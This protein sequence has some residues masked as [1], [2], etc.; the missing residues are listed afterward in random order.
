MT[1]KFA[2]GDQVRL[3]SGGP[4]MTVIVV[5]SDLPEA[6]DDTRSYRCGWFNVCGELDYKFAQDVFPGASLTLIKANP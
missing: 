6:T 1:M 2:I 3:N 5:S 4:T